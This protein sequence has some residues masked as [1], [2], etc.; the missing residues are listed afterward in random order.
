MA[1][2][3][4]LF[5]LFF[6]NG[7]NSQSP[8]QMEDELDEF[9]DPTGK[10][11]KVF[12]G[13]GTWD[14]GM[15]KGD[16]DF[17]LIRRKSDALELFIFMEGEKVIFHTGQSDEDEQEVTGPPKDVNYGAIM[18]KYP[19]GSKQKLTGSAM[20]LWD[21]TVVFRISGKMRK[22]AIGNPDVSIELA[23]QSKLF[24]AGDETYLLQVPVSWD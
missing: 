8:W 23:I 2:V 20:Y 13:I 1:K 19:D 12:S 22:L 16:F 6:L 17:R 3:A 5:F 14:N 11:I 4:L 7:M 18:V 10:Q 24:G 15:Y 9:G 21:P